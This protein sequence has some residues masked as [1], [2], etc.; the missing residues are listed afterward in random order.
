MTNKAKTTKDPDTSTYDEAMNDS[1]T[2]HWIDSAILEVHELSEHG[3][4]IEV[5]IESVLECLIVIPETW[6][7]VIIVIRMKALR[8]SK[9]AWRLGNHGC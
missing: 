1:D 6:V 5:P 2:H 7:Y 8:N 3:T 9:S 4:W